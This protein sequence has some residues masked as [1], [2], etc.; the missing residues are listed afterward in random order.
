MEFAV[1]CIGCVADELKLS[2]TEVYDLLNESHL[3]QDYIIDFYDVLHTQSRE[4][5]VT[6]IINVMKEKGLI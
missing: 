1:F 4:Y 6:D 5:I 2:A 3:L